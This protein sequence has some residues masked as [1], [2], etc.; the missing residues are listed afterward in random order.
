LEGGENGYTCSDGASGHCGNGEYCHAETA[1]DKG[2]WGDGCAKKPI[3]QCTNPCVDVSG[4]YDDGEMTQDG[5][6]L[7][8]KAFG[9]TGSVTGNS[10]IGIGP[11]GS[12]PSSTNARGT[13]HGNVIMWSDVDAPDDGWARQPG[14]NNQGGKNGYTRDKIRYTCSDGTNGHC[15][16]DEYC[17]AKDGF[18]KGQLSDG[19]VKNPA[20]PDDRC[21]PSF[22]GISCNVAAHKY[23]NEINGWCGNTETHKAISNHHGNNYDFGV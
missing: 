2:Q 15:A 23:C 5:C 18:V 21:G 12:Y 1:F 22:G 13:L 7:E 19:C 4:T 14:S 9:A 8:F 6:N 10:V 3:C 16:S 17:Y 11:K 20:R